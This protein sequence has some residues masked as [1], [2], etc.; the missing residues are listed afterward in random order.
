MLAR[1]RVRLSVCQGL[2]YSMGNEAHCL[3]KEPGEE[4]PPETTTLDD[5][6]RPAIVKL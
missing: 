2:L 6:S 1:P 4:N 5:I 3:I